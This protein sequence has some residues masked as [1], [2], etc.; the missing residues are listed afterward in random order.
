[1]TPELAPL[2][3]NYHITP[4][5]GFRAMHDKDPCQKARIVLKPFE[6]H[7][8]EFQLMSSTPN[9]PD[10]YLKE[11]IW[12]FTEMELRDQTSAIHNILTLCNHCDNG[13]DLSTVIYQELVDSMP[14][15]VAA[16]LEAKKDA[17]YY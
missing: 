4:T 10:L 3:A 11:Y 7:K 5:G 6:E 9:S 17:E 14:R 1:M 8:Q 2:C 15:R 13:C 16:I 12:V